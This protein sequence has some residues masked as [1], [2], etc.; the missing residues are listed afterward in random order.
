MITMNNINTME[1]IHT[2]N[3][4]GQGIVTLPKAWREKMKTK[5]FIARENGNQL[6]LEPLVAEENIK[7]L[8]ENPSFDFLRNEPDLYNDL[9]D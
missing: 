5:K 4:Y 3:M 2:L 6:I 1:I 9:V 8:T 7:M